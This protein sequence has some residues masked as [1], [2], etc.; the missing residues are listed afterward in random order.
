MKKKII[1]IRTQITLDDYK[2]FYYFGIGKSKI[3]NCI[4]P[5][6]FS[7]VIFKDT[8]SRIIGALILIII[9]FLFMEWE[10]RKGYNQSKIA[11][12]V[13]IL[14]NFYEDGLENI[15]VN[16]SYSCFIKWEKVCTIR[17]HKNYI[18]LMTSENAGTIIKKQD[19]SSEDLL[20]LENL[21]RD[22][23]DEE[24]LKKS[25]YAK[26]KVISIQSAIRYFCLLLFLLLLIIFYIGLLY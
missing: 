8:T 25:K 4:I 17:S 14:S 7:L 26:W 9:N 6:L 5:I 13:E 2:N 22:N 11:L 12:G 3:A 19:M 20:K 10:V 16:G 18:I 23:F 15:D 1:E 21:L 24:V